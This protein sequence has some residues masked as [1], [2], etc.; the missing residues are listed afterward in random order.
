MSRMKTAAK[1]GGLG[2]LGLAVASGALLTIEGI[3]ATRRT[4]LLAES[5]PPVEGRFKP[6]GTS[7][8]SVKLTMLGDSTAA[9]VGASSTAGTVGGHLAQSLALRGFT[10]QLTSVAISGS[11]VSD[12]GPQ[13]SRALLAHPEVALILI[14]ANDA[15]HLTRK[16]AITR[17][18]GDAITRLESAGAKVIVGTCPDMGA[19]DSFLQPLRQIVAWEGRRIGRMERAVIEG[20]EA[21]PVDI[22]AHTGP[23]IRRDRD[24]YL[25]SDRFHPSDAGYALWSDALL[26]AVSWAATELAHSPIP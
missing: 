20:T 16:D 1:R 7:T 3:L 26:P 8:G 12:L 17:H 22:G 23:E 13:V 15:T 24:R 10:V 25:S 11:R 19:S 21:I 18:L 14:G 6:Q 5:A 2:V 4:Y 9:G